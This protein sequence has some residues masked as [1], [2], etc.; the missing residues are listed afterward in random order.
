MASRKRSS[1]PSNSAALEL[2]LGLML[3]LACCDAKG[4][5]G[6]AIVAIVAVDEAA[7]S[8]ELH[9]MPETQKQ[10]VVHGHQQHVPHIIKDGALRV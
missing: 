5:R 2:G 9:A 3:G 6:E 1:W 7:K 8:C 4:D 10:Q